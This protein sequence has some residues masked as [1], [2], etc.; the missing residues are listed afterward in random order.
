MGTPHPPSGVTSGRILLQIIIIISDNRNIMQIVYVLEVL[1][2]HP[3]LAPSL[4][5]GRGP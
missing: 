4:L 1:V 2:G 5:Q 3:L